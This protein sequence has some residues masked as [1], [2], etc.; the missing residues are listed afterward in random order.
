MRCACSRRA[1]LTSLW[2][3]GSLASPQRSID[4][5]EGRSREGQDRPLGHPRRA[6]DGTG[7]SG[8]HRTYALLRLGVGHRNHSH[9]RQ[10]T[11]IDPSRAN[12]RISLQLCNAA[13]RNDSRRICHIRCRL[14]TGPAGGRGHLR[15]Y[16][17]LLL[18]GGSARLSQ[19]SVPVAERPTMVRVYTTRT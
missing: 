10:R 14:H 1:E 8:R 17:A 15:T 3:R 7:A 9:D 11:A 6:R 12:R 5:E 19:S 13:L 16:L 2:R 4:H 18:S